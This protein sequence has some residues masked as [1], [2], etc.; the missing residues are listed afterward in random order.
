M[1][2]RYTPATFIRE[3]LLILATIVVLFPFYLLVVMALKGTKEATVSSPVALP[4]APTLE[5]FATVLSGEGSR[6]VLMGLLNSTIITVGSVVMLI[7]LGS[8]AAYAIAR[9]PGRLGGA[10]YVSFVVGIILPFQLAIIPTY[11]ALRVLG[12]LGTH[13][14]MILLYTG[15]LMPL[16]VFLYTG[17]ARALPR[18]YEEAAAI[19][20]ASKIRIFVKIVFPLLAPATGTVAI[21]TGLIVWNDFFNALI[22]LSGSRS[23][24]LPVMVYSFVGEN[25]TAWNLVFTVVIISMI[26]ILAFYLFAQKKFI[27]G[28]AGGMKG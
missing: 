16:T 13:V 8:V 11:V 25:V 27:Q 20:G 9:R 21:L 10:A 18:D 23:T 1:F 26:P 2:N 19:D 4:T 5:N 12:L 24:T 6:N 17:F 22:F 7:I 15:L 3:V 28:F 14:G